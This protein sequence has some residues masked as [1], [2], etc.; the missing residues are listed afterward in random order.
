MDYPGER[1]PGVHWSAVALGKVWYWV[2]ERIRHVRLT[3]GFSGVVLVLATGV[4]FA[5]R[6][7]VGALGVAAGVLLVAASYT[8]S[9]LAI[10][11]ADTVNPRMVLPVGMGMYITKFSLLGLLLVAV[12]NAEWVGRIPMAMGIVVGILA[13]TASQIWWTVHHSHPYVPVP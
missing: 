5:V 2:A 6:G 8:A 9:T 13:W 3:L 7:G 10:A 11:W 12:N 1:S 4:G